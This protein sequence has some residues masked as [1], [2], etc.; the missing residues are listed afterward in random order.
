[1]ENSR[2]A[3]SLFTIS[4]RLCGTIDQT[5]AA[6]ESMVSVETLAFRHEL[7]MLTSVFLPQLLRNIA[8]GHCTVIYQL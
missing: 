4:S 6:A 7:R 5:Y 8:S 3:R 2:K 1:M